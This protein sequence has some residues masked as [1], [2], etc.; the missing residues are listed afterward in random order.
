MSLISLNSFNVLLRSFWNPLSPAYQWEIYIT[1]SL[2][3]H[4]FTSHII[5]IANIITLFQLLITSFWTTAN[6]LLTE[7]P[8]S[9]MV[10]PFQ[11]IHG[12]QITVPRA[13]LCIALTQTDVHR[14]PAVCRM[15]SKFLRL[16]FKDYCTWFQPTF[17]NIFPI[18]YLHI[19]WT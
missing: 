16:P 18:N 3:K 10:S 4:L 9:S 7:L 2:Y 13:K 14:L 15:K 17:P 12:Y 5:F 1:V 11:P 19:P 6:S 8:I